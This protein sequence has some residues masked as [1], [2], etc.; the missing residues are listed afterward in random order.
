MCLQNWGAMRLRG[1]E[2]HPGSG[3]RGGEAWRPSVSNV[4][5]AS[6]QQIFSPYSFS[7]LYSISG[8]C[9]GFWLTD[10]HQL[11]G[12][13]S[14]QDT[15]NIWCLVLYSL[16]YLLVTQNCCLCKS[17]IL[18]TNYFPQYRKVWLFT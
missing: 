12:S 6:P 9:H 13:K 16:Q 2:Q 17:E 11:I 18:F 1:Q 10:L 15:Y 5:I 4:V 14:K 8:A 3:G 7:Y